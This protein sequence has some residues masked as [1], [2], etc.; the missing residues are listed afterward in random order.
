ML[1][2][3]YLFSTQPCCRV[4]WTGRRGKMA[5]ESFLVLCQKPGTTSH[6]T[7]SERKLIRE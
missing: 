4:E 1:Q 3:V 5:G 2:L 6:D 7:F